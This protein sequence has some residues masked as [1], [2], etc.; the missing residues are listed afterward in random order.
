MPQMWR[1]GTLYTPLLS[2]VQSDANVLTVN[3][4]SSV[5][6][7]KRKYEFLEYMDRRLMKNRKLI[8]EELARRAKPKSSEPSDPKMLDVKVNDD[9]LDEVEEEA[10]EGTGSSP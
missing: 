3:E 6:D 7:L 10:K 4:Q 8:L 1:V 9:Y 2:R 5:R